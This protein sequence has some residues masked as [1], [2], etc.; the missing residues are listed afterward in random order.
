MP[1]HTKM[2]A[3][4]MNQTI[5]MEEIV[6][7]YVLLEV[8]EDQRVIDQEREGEMEIVVVDVMMMLNDNPSNR[9]KG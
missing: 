4:L 9:E 1:T 5:M 8:V 2:M 3:G 6:V 7:L